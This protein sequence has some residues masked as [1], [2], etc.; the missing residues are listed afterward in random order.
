MKRLL[1]F[2][3]LFIPVFA[4]AQRCRIPVTQTIFQQNFN[5][6]AV[7]RGDESKQV[8]AEQFVTAN[9]V[10]SLQLKSLAQLFSGDSIRLI[11][12]ERAYPKV[13]DTANFYCVYDAFT[14]FSY[15]IR[16]YDWVQHNKPASTVL[17]GQIVTTPVTPTTPVSNGPTYPAWIYP[18]TVRTTSSRGCAGPVITETQFT[19]IAN[20]V[21]RQPTE[22]SKIVAIENASAQN[23]LSM[24]QLMKLASMLTNEDNRMRVMKNGFPRVY[25]QEHYSFAATMFSVAAKKDEWNNYCAAYLTPP[26]TVSDQDFNGL[27]AQ[28]RAK[29]F[30]DDQKVLVKMMAND[31]CFNVAQLKTIADEFPFDEDKMEIFKLCYS[32]CPD[33]QNYYQLVDKLSF[34]SNKDELNRFINAGGH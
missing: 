16:L 26:C 7:L 28:I 20:N 13:T 15:A 14:S 1:L 17:S 31:R 6:I 22:E 4:S 10:N 30:D 9:C 3:L 5:Q 12:C 34:S 19:T 32:K 33:K 8:R 21:H 25:D 23:C 29:T 24:A 18:D 27:M 11:V 2:S